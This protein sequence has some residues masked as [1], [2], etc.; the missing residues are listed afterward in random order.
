MLTSSRLGRIGA[1]AVLVAAMTAGAVTTALAGTQAAAPGG[2]RH[3]VLAAPDGLVLPDA[4]TVAQPHGGAGWMSHAL[5][6]RV[7]G[8]TH[9][10]ADC[11][12]MTRAI[13]DTQ[14]APVNPG[15]CATPQ[16]TAKKPVGYSPAQLRGLLGLHGTGAG[17]RVAIVDAYDNPYAE[18]DITAFSKQFGLPLPCAAGKQASSGCFTF[19][20]VHPYGFDGVDAGW[21]L[22]SDL[23]VEMVHAIAPQASITLVE[24]Y[25][26]TTISL[27]QAIKYAGSLTPA[28]SAIS[29][30]WGEPE[31]SGEAQGYPACALT[32]TLCVFAAGDNGNPGQFPAYD[33]SVLAVGGTTLSLSADG[34]PGMEVAWCCTDPL[35]PGAGGGGVSKYEV[36]PAY[37]NGLNPYLGRSIPDVSFDADPDTGVPVYDTMGLNDQN[38]WF[39]VGGTSVGTPVWSGI[40]AVADQLRVAAG[41]PPLAG[42]QFQ[43]LDLLYSQARH[44]APG[45]S[46]ITAGADNMIECTSPVRS[47]QAHPGFDEVSGWGSP[48]PGIDETLASP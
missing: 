6:V 39:E 14:S 27:Y 23:D 34:K 37:Q 42:A 38:G 24:A 12:L 2:P 20:R 16:L 21:A 4:E 41:R 32:K 5:M 3:T 28:P 33:P 15:R 45:F 48:R 36:R 22:E 44:H 8:W 19:S 46:D 1:A 9:R 13:A 40:V 30:S 7:P 43:A 11:A 25:D 10:G 47:C 31:F 17:E 26:A 35:N 29:N 18:R